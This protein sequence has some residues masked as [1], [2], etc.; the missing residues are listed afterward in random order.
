[1]GK[2]SLKKGDN[3]DDSSSRLALFGSRS[4]SKSPAPPSQNPYAQ[5]AIPPDPYTRAKMSAGI[6]PPTEQRPSG[7]DSR[8]SKQPGPGPQS[9]VSGLPGPGQQKP[10]P[11]RD[12]PYGGSQ[13]S[14]G[15]SQG[16]YGN[17]A[18]GYGADKFGNQNG[19]GAAGSGGNPY[20]SIQQPSGTSRQG[21]YGGLGPSNL[22]DNDSSRD[23]LF[24]GAR[25]RMEQKPKNQVD[26]APDYQYN[27][28]NDAGDRS[29]G[30]YGDRQLTAEEEEEEDINAT[31]QEVKFMKQQ[32]VAS[33]RN[34]LRIAA[35][36]E[37]MGR[38]TLARLGAQG[39]R[40][41]NTDRNLDIGTNHI[42]LAEDKTK[43]LKTL[44]RSMFAVHVNN[45]FTAKDRRARRDEQIMDRHHAE[46]E[47]REATREAAFHSG[48]RM[49]Q[50]FKGL[51]EVSK[52]AKTKSSLA[53]RAKYQFEADSEDDAMEDEIDRNLDDL[54]GAAKRLN[55][56]ARATGEEVEQQ[57]Q[58]IQ[59]IAEKSD[60]F[61]DR[62]HFQTEKLKRI[63]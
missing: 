6:I 32:D 11:G 9:R 60:R 59:N 54:T 46:R 29:Y 10:P 21:G 19:Y 22:Y 28:A 27:P 30:A 62:L 2:F 34:A 44:N 58:L 5:P 41:H 55:M 57:N 16:G 49:N 26:A 37:E 61:D 24:G 51:D 23:E 18:G 33:T 8:G 42:N 50:N 38:N 20:G 25:E 47:S 12:N 48:Q 14:Y 53:E 31:K 45:P 56:L 3:D 36:A 63:K 13:P 1:M 40:M 43:E 17:N 52:G 15:A 39:E 4:K 7:P 35:Q